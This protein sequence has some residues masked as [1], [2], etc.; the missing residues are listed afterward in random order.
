MLNITFTP[1]PELGTQRLLLRQLNAQDA[2][3]L[4]SLRSME[5]MNKY[6]DRPNTLSLIEAQQLIIKLNNGIKDNNWIFWAV[7]CKPDDRLIGTACLWNIAKEVQRAELGYE[8]HPDFQ[9]KGIMLEGVTKVLDYGFNRMLLKKI[10]AV[11]H[12]EN[13]ASIKLLGKLNFNRDEEAKTRAGDKE[14]KQY[15]FYSLNRP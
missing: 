8:L 15:V 10:E 13:N 9:G 11:V 2:G 4:S 5:S 1:F 14:L 6:I 7:T 12:E 3:N